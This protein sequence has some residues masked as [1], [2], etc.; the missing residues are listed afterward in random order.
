M[1][2]KIII[3][4][5]AFLIFFALSNLVRAQA[6]TSSP[7][8]TPSAIID[9]NIK[10]LKD[11]IATKVAELQKQNKKVITGLIAAIGKDSLEL[12]S[13]E[14]TYK[15]AVDDTLTKIYSITDGWQKEIKLEDLLKDDFVIV[16]GVLLE[17]SVNANYIYK[18]Q[19]YVVS[20]GKV[21][22]VNKDDYSIK[23]I[24]TDKNE[25][26]LDFESTTKQLI[27]DP[28]TLSI[29]RAGFSKIK[30]G[31]II[32]FVF[33]KPKE[34]KFTRVLALRTLLIPQEYFAK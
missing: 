18:D 2:N 21:S 17:N 24:T 19:A 16:L 8:S 1:K 3:I 11:K 6:T 25:Y 12:R 5:G 23:I 31:D 32:H 20:S 7:T 4:T 29:N 28:K 15:I 10:A 33:K 30:E 22:E 27:L 13:K 26:T 9:E 34:E 14:N